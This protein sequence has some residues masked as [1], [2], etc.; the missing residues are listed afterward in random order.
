[1]DPSVRIADGRADSGSKLILDATRKID[2]GT[3][4]LPP[5]PIMLKGGWSLV[6]SAIVLCYDA[7]QVAATF[8]PLA[9]YMTYLASLCYPNIN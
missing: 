2:S 7:G 5:K 3:F 8:A 1:M 4:S 9:Q 6:S